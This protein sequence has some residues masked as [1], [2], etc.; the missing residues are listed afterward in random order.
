[1]S[2]RTRPRFRQ[3]VL[4]TTHARAS[5][6]F[7][8]A[9]LGLSYRPG[10][11]PPPPGEDDVAGRDWITLQTP[12]GRSLLGFQQVASL[13]P[14]TWP[15]GPVPQQLHLDLEV[16]DLTELAAVHELVLSLG[17]V[18]SD[19]RSEDEN[20]RLYVYTD[21]DGHPFCVFLP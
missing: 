17:G 15:K 14:A 5:A 16:A 1:M 9:L 20:E 4:D 6:E 7:W 21:L 10:D 13:T 3:I 2:E 19:D 12:D 18:V 8:R 11:E